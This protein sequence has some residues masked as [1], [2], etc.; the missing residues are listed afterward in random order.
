LVLEYEDVLN[1]QSGKLGL[2]HEEIDD[3]LDYLCSVAQRRRIFFLWRTVLR[4]PKDEFVLELAVEGGCDFI[5]TYNER[6][7]SG[8][9]R[10]GI[11]TMTPCGFLRLIEVLT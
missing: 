1:R 11:Q 10:F 9:E 5:L 3:V 6:D 2:C 8:A 7:F 4:D